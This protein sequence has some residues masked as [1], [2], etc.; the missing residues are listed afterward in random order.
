[1]SENKTFLSEL[2]ALVKKHVAPEKLKFADVTLPDGSVLR[3]P[4]DV[5]VIQTPA[6]IVQP[7]GSEL[8]APD[9]TYELPDG[10]ELEVIGGIITTVTPGG[11]AEVES[12]E[13][14]VAESCA[15]GAK[16]AMSDSP[17]SQAVK[18]IVETHTK[19]HH[20]TKEEVDAKL[21]DQSVTL[22]ESFAAHTKELSDKLAEMEAYNKDLA[23][24]VMKF[25]DEPAEKSV[26]D[27]K[28][29]LRSESKPKE[30]IEDYRKRMWG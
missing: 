8:P 26:K 6:T 3:F 23:A 10:T 13:S 18:S 14:P 9:A 25:A 29:E 30:S 12:P 5:A 22:S 7:D 20:F 24:L 17:N 21:A 27:I 2:A 15:P 11:A 1:M 19:E 4:G 16:A 28:V